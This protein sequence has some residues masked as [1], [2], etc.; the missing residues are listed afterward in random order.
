MVRPLYSLAYGSYGHCYY[1][2]VN[3]VYFDMQV[4]LIQFCGIVFLPLNSNK[5]IA[6]EGD[7]PQNSQ[8]TYN[9]DIEW[10][11]P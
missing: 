7:T 5:Q 9:D 6:L 10:A 11:G 4:N 1:F 3:Y 8:T 2:L